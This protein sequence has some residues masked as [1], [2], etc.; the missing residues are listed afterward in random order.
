VPES[1]SIGSLQV[2]PPFDET[3]RKTSVF[4]TGLAESCTPFRLSLKTSQSFPSVG[5]ATMLPAVLTR[6]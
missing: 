1:T 6:T 4:V 2:P 5:L 3:T